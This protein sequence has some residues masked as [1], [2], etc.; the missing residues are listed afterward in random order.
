[1]DLFFERKR[2]SGG[3]IIGAGI[4]WSGKDSLVFVKGTLDAQAYTDMLDDYYQPF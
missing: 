2:C 1:M 4:S 3:V